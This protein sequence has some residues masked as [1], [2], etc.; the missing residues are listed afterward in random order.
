M[1]I[2]VPDSWM[3]PSLVVLLFLFFTLLIAALV[4]LGIA[5]ERKSRGEILRVLGKGLGWFAAF[6]LGSAGID[7]L[8]SV[9]NFPSWSNGFLSGLTIGIVVLM[10]MRVGEILGM[11]RRSMAG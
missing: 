2:Y 9:F 7:Y 8:L 10:R 4:T 6:C 11:L 1:S 5:L 3:L